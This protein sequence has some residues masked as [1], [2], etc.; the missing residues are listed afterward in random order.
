[1]DKTEE[2][3]EIARQL[4]KPTGE[5][6]LQIAKFMNDGNE[7]LNRNTIGELKL[8]PNAKVLEIGMGNGAFVHELF[9]IEPDLT[10]YGFDYS[11][12]MISEA[13][14]L[15]EYLVEQGKAIFTFGEAPNWPFTSNSFDAIFSVNTVY[16][17]KDPQHMLNEIHS[18]LKPGGQLCLGLRPERLMIN[19]PFVQ[20]G[21]TTYTKEKLS[22][23]FLKAGFSH[24]RSEVVPEPP[25]EREGELLEVE[26]LVV[27]GVK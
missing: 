14:K 23:E 27:C 24:I 7:L 13:T 2:Y 21:F 11:E 10:Y 8:V 15:N 25:F 18:L 17:W 9:K 12:L 6:G 22:Q 26:S 4:Q 3:R 19:Y 20:Y 5:N 1:M 16:F